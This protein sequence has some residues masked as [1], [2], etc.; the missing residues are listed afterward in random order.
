[1]NIC[2]CPACQ[3]QFQAP[4]D[5]LAGHALC[6]ECHIQVRVPNIKQEQSPTTA[7]DMLTCQ[8]GAC[9]MKFQVSESC[10]G[11]VRQCPDCSQPVHIVERKQRSVGF[12]LIVVAIVMLA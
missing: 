5:R 3:A 11:S 8:C 2:K 6:P 1:M 4:D 7:S 12:W 9:G 10:E